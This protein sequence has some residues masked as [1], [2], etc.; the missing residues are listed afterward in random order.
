MVGGG[1]LRGVD[2]QVGHL[3]VESAPGPRT[4]AAARS[5][6]RAAGTGARRR[7]RPAPRARRAGCAG[8]RPERRYV[9]AARR[10]PPAPRLPRR[11]RP[12]A[13]RGRRPPGAGPRT[14]CRAGRRPRPAP[15]A[16]PWAPR[17]APRRASRC[18]GTPSRCALRSPRRP[19]SCRSPSS[20]AAAPGCRTGR[21]AGRR[22]CRRGGRSCRRGGHE[23]RPDDPEPRRP[24][25]HV[26]RHLVAL[27]H[28][29]GRAARGRC[30]PCGSGEN[31]PLVTSPTAA[32]SADATDMC[33]RG[34]AR[35]RPSS[36][37]SVR[38]GPASFSA[39]STSRPQKASFFQPT[40]HPVRAWTGVMSIDRSCPC[41]G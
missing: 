6:G 40:A 34:I 37:H 35:S 41:S 24:A 20:R 23:R 22:S 31:V 39:S 33:D 11:R 26:D 2:D 8:R 10:P 3:A 16:L 29:R 19:R 28:R 9:A 7:R 1:A 13:A 17:R 36:P 4:A 18:R 12:P 38:R 21:L 32:P 27:A 5:P 15:A 14:R 30:R 25:T